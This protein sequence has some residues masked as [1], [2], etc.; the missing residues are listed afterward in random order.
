LLLVPGNP[1]SQRT[2][3]LLRRMQKAI[4]LF[5]GLRLY[6]PVVLRVR[7]T[8]C[9]PLRAV[10]PLRTATALFPVALSIPDLTQT[11][12]RGHGD[13]ETNGAHRHIG[14]CDPRAR[15]DSHLLATSANHA[16]VWLTKS[17]CHA[18]T[19]TSPGRTEAEVYRGCVCR[20]VALR[21]IPPRGVAASP[22]HSANAI[23]NSSRLFCEGNGV[24]QGLD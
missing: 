18:H 9:A 22:Q 15:N 13:R 23:Q 10:V 2:A 8:T 3:P 14:P 1:G 12:R 24:H 7:R 19:W 6:L 21:Q 20:R 5:Y 16:D 11:A 4:P 17:E